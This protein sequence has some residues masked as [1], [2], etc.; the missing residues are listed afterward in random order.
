MSYTNETTHYSIPLPLGSDLTTPMDYNTAMQDVDTALFESKTDS[1]SALQKANQLQE[2]LSDTND[3]VT[4]LDGRLTSVEGIQT[5][6]GQNILQN[7]QDIADVRADALDMIC[8]VDEGT[9]QVAS[10]KVDEGEYF[11]YN[12][13]LYIATTDIAIGDTIVPNTNC[14][15]T[16]VA[17]ELE[18]VDE[19]IQTSSV[20]YTPIS[21]GFT[22][23]SLNVNKI[24]NL[25]IIDFMGN[26]TIKINEV[27]NIA[28]ISGL[29]IP[30]QFESAIYNSHGSI[31]SLNLMTNGNI[32]LYCDSESATF[33][34]VAGGQLIAVL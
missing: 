7:A 22:V 9:A 17:T 16:N 18:T 29:T 31:V 19:N 15:A 26:G 4:A 20:S 12:D 24:G 23:S 33:T 25:L 5:T 32:C 27:T 28:N 1:S 21:D 14:R 2:D 6:Q 3:D 10:V 8:A 30:R 34:A 11:R 13:V